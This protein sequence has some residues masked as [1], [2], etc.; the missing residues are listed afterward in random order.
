MTHDESHPLSNG[1]LT[2]FCCK[3]LYFCTVCND[4]IVRSKASQKERKDGLDELLWAITSIAKQ[5]PCETVGHWSCTNALRAVV[6]IVKSY[7][8]GQA[9]VNEEFNQGLQTTLLLIV[10]AIEKEILNEH[11][12]V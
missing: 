10:N 7:S 12:K 1:G 5:D 9:Y 3:D 2:C 6:E 4:N 8:D 11:V